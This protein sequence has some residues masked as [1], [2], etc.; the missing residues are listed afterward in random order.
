MSGYVSSMTC[1]KGQTWSIIY[2]EMLNTFQKKYQ[3][4]KFRLRLTANWTPLWSSPLL[5]WGDI[6][7]SNARCEW[8]NDENEVLTVCSR[9]FKAQCVFLNGMVPSTVSGIPLHEWL[10]LR[11]LSQSVILQHHRERPMWHGHITS[12]VVWIL[13]LPNQV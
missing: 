1:M 10:K 2:W 7:T 3:M 8:G 9:R 5:N 4:I 13:N 6:S 12:A 11:L